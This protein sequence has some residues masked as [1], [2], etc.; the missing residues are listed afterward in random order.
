[1]YPFQ[2]VDLMKGLLVCLFFLEMHANYLSFSLV[3]K[4][5]MKFGH[6][7]LLNHEIVVTSN[8]HLAFFANL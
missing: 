2:E 6:S 4:V 8:I 5:P 3:Y 1:M 7:L